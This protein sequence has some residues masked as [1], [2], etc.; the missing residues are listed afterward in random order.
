[1]KSETARSVTKFLLA[2][3]NCPRHE[4]AE[5]RRRRQQMRVPHVLTERDQTVEGIKYVLVRATSSGC[6]RQRRR[7]TEVARKVSVRRTVL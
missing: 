4:G 5:A 2:R 7:W 6:W 1:M 3:R